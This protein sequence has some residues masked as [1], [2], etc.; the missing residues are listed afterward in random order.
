MDKRE[1]G[2]ALREMS[3]VFAARRGWATRADII[4]TLPLN[5]M[6]EALKPRAARL[7]RGRP[8]GEGSR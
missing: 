8:C 1:I 6:L 7:G 2:P 5:R 3:L 4:N